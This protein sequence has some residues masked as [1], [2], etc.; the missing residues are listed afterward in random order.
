VLAGKVSGTFWNHGSI[1][2]LELKNASLCLKDVEMLFLRAVGS[3]GDK[4]TESL[5]KKSPQTD[6]HI[7]NTESQ[8]KD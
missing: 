1:W 7:Y 8:E 6:N 3:L 4:A 5:Q 2:N